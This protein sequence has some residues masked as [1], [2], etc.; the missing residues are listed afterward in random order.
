MSA[1]LMLV[2]PHAERT[3]LDAWSASFLLFGGVVIACRIAFARL[4]DR[5]PP[6]RLAGAALVLVAAGLITTVV[7]PG[8]TGLLAGT[9]VLGAGVAF[10]TPAIFAAV[11]SRIPAAER[12][13]GAGTVTVF[14]DL[15]F[16]G[17]PFLAGYVAA[18]SG[19]P[20]AFVAAG[21]VALV[22]ALGAL[23][24]PGLVRAQPA[25]TS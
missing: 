14:I 12:G 11:F 4:P 17:G 18:S 24:L 6:M 19:V 22:G 25:L 16:A 21:L 8:L 1:F 15:G 9:A 13:A 3:G 2:G 7:A 10:M 23:F 20:M 5:V